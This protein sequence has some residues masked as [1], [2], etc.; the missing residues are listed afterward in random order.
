V[1]GF[2]FSGVGAARRPLLDVHLDADRLVPH[3]CLVDS[4][5]LGVR[6][7]AELAHVAGIELPARPSGPDLRIAGVRHQVRSAAVP[8]SCTVDGRVLRWQAQVTF[9]D[10]WPHPFGILGL[11]GF[12][13]RFD[14]D[15]RGA[16]GAFDVRPAA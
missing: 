8:L 4:G 3:T 9:C 13:D 2:R 15:L 14:V 1:I 5:A 7:S 12:L 10:P 6:L 11:H 16:Q